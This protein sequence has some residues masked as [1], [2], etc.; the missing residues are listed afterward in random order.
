LKL[1]ENKTGVIRMDFERVVAFHGHA[2]PGLAIGFR[3]ANMALK[4]F[5]EKAKDE[6][7]VAIVENNSCAVDAVQVMAGCTFGKG[8]L[9]FRDYGK[10]V[11]T[12]LSRATGKAV[13]IAVAWEPPPAEVESPAETE[14]WIRYAAGERSAE[15]MQVVHARKTRKMQMILSA[16]EGDLFAVTYPDVT[17]PETAHI[18]PS[19]TCE[20][21]GEKVMEPRT[22]KEG[23]KVLC[24]PCAEKP[25]D[26]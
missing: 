22:R 21:C 25:G 5:G 17:L 14:M 19:I 6:E 3:V 11:Y 10:Q 24:I 13:R 18:Y 20:A 9:L 4:E 2:C 1:N 7:L 12:F 23:G 8:N 26:H 15:V 16:E